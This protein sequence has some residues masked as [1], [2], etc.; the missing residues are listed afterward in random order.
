LTRAERDAVSSAFMLTL[1]LA[2]HDPGCVKTLCF[3][4]FSQQ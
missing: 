1:N 3:M 4:R 2:A